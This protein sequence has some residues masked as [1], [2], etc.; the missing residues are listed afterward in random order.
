MITTVLGSR[1]G[2]IDR[3]SY[4]GGY[5]TVVGALDGSRLSL[6]ILSDTGHRISVAQSEALLRQ[7][8][9]R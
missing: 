8:R 1:L 6:V 2:L 5:W 4:P 7:V 9:A 3:R